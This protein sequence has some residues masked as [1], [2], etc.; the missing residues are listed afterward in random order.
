MAL[1]FDENYS[2]WIWKRSVSVQ[3]PW[4]P[5]QRCLGSLLLNSLSSLERGYSSPVQVDVDDVLGTHERDLHRNIRRIRLDG[6]TGNVIGKVGCSPLRQKGA[7][8]TPRQS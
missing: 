5:E 8:L 6:E 1:C 4:R 3:S 2:I 7:Q